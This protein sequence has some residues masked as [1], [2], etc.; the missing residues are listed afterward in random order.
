MLGGQ[1]PHDLVVGHPLQMRKVQGSIPRVH[2]GNSIAAWFR[3]SDIRLTC[4]ASSI[5]N[6]SVH[7]RMRGIRLIRWP[8]IRFTRGGSWVRSPRGTR[9]G[10]APHSSMV[11][12]LLHMREVSGSRPSVPGVARLATTDDSSVSLSCAG[13]ST[14]G[15]L[16]SHQW[17]VHVMAP[18]V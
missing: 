5:Q 8:G 11:G 3:C 1:A 15:F 16:K 6:A 17:L 4:G 7:R 18:V 13:C 14:T 2:A 9:N 10:Q 12:Q